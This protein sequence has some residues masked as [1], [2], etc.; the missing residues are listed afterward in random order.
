MRPTSARRARRTTT[1]PS[2]RAATGPTRPIPRPSSNASFIGAADFSR[3]I[4]LAHAAGLQPTRLSA[5]QNLLAQ[6]AALYKADSGSYGSPTV[7]GGVFGALAAAR[8]GVPRAVLAKSAAFVRAQQHDDGG[9]TIMLVTS[10]AN[11]AAPGD[12]DMTGVAIGVLCETG[13]TPDDPAV[14]RGIAFLRDKLISATGGFDA[15]FGANADS[16]AWAIEGLSACGVDA[17]SAA[18]T[19]PAGKTPVDFLLTLQRTSGPNAGSFKWLPTDGDDDAPNLYSSQNALRAVAGGTFTADPP[20]R[21]NPG[22]PVVRPAPTVA[23][24]TPVPLALAVDDGHGDVRLC[25]VV[26]PAGVTVA[27]VLT[28]AQV[29][30]APLGCVDERGC[31]RRRRGDERQRRGRRLARQR[32]RRP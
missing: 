16:N 9:W 19:T 14:A 6:L 26:A 13:A 28:V 25:R 10:P 21:A 12:I 32:R 30:S 15:M 31:G 3:A 17:Q 11:A 22:D 7:T 23:D 1:S 20:A 24:G 29:A 8:A 4:L 2:G 18:W 27:D 5:E